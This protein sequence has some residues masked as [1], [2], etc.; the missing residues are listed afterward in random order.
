MPSSGGFNTFGN[1]WKHDPDKR[2]GAISEREQITQD[3][4]S[5]RVLIGLH[6]SLHDWRCHKYFDGS[7]VLL[8]PL[9]EGG[10]LIKMR[11]KG[12]GLRIGKERLTSMYWR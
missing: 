6:D 12:R 1:P 4:P 2:G 5:H 10:F 3:L 11:P 8:V 9:G 7:L